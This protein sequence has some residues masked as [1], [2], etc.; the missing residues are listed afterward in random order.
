M[1]GSVTERLIPAYK[2]STS[3]VRTVNPALQ[4]EGVH[5]VFPDGVSGRPLGNR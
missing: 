3:I 1:D 2:A 4:G 5:G